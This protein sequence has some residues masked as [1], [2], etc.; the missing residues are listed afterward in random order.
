MIRNLKN[1]YCHCECKL[2][3]GMEEHRHRNCGHTDQSLE[4]RFRPLPNS[5]KDREVLLTYGEAK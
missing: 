5:L 4:V 1:L 2:C 3:Q